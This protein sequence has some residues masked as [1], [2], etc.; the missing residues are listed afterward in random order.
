M[1][2]Q[3][4]VALIMEESGMRWLS[5]TDRF[6]WCLSSVLRATAQRITLWYAVPLLLSVGHGL[7][8]PSLLSAEVGI[9][10]Q[11]T[12][13]VEDRTLSRLLKEVSETWDL[14]K[15][16]P[17]SLNLLRRRAERDSRT[18][19]KV[20]RSQAYYGAHVAI[21][22]ETECKPIH[23]VFRI[24]L[25]P[26]YLLGS[27]DIG[28]PESMASMAPKL[29][30]AH[31]IGLTLDE[32]A[33]SAS[34]LNAEQALVVWFKN[35][36]FPLVRITERQVVVDHDVKRVRVTFQTDPG[37]PA[38]FGTTEIV[39]LESLDEAFVRNKIPWTRG[40]QFNSRLLTDLQGRL[41][42]TGLFAS[43]QVAAAKAVDQGGFLPVTV[44]VKERKHRTIRAGV[45]YRTDEGAGG[46][47][48]W[49]HRNFLG[50]GERL[51]LTG[52]VSEIALAG[53]GRF[54]KPDFFRVDQSLLL[55]ARTA[56]DETD[57]YTSQ[58]TGGSVEIE[59]QLADRTLLGVGLSYRA[60]E[61]EQL[62]K[63]DRFGLIS[64]PARFN[65]D[66]SD[67]L[68]DPTR[69]GR[70][71]LK[72]APF[73]DTLSQNLGFVKAYASYSRYLQLLENPLVVL[74]G[75]GA[76]GSIAGAARDEIPA[77]ERY[78]AGGGESI[79]GFPYQSVGPRVDSEPVGGRSLLELSLELR[80]K[81]T[82]TVGFVVFVDGGSAFERVLPDLDEEI[83]WGSGIGLRYFSPV[84]PLRV[85]IG[86]PLNKRSQID[87]DFQIYL[88]LGQ[89]F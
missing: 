25:G 21:N 3:V 62:D 9:P 4:V 67:N 88:S 46:K 34:I 85:D 66:T 89:A 54:R 82:R 15:N 63:T 75:R 68:L 27:V 5:I 51:T 57:A 37:P 29:P 41:N 76:L 61:V 74:A 86:F 53:E 38:R 44:T 22:I 65:W 19:T 36:G 83:G 81:V 10:Y 20:L 48:S 59:R 64:L 43:V 70:L 1:G 18:F 47:L 2:D 77:D 31:E 28:I 35:R 45:S 24:D 16:P 32:P 14:R 12:I 42:R 33:T 72:F 78:Y 23:V 56:L 50:S 49:E 79:R 69:G 87:D 6:G 71:A 40:D 60:S 55:N 13:E 58:S 84:G 26:P 11:L 52:T 39:G 30:A 73:H 8:R 7:C 80:L 17:A